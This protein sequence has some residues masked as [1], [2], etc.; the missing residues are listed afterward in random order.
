MLKWT[1]LKKNKYFKIYTAI[2]ILSI[3]LGFLFYFKL[4]ENINISEINLELLIKNHSIYHIL[5]VSITFFL[6]FLLIGS[7]L[8]IMGFCFEL[9][10]IVILGIGLFSA[11]HIRGLFL[12]I[13]LLTFKLF[14]LLL[15]IYLITRGFKI[16]KTIVSKQSHFKGNILIYIKEA[17]YT[18]LII[19][20]IETFNYFIGY[21]II[22]FFTKLLQIML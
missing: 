20:A 15:L 11:Y 8:G 6:S 1:S 10:S 5:F 14:Y 3:L 18:S 22:T 19:I 21:K 9:I 17:I 16:A 12:F 4:K 7:F 13:T 2:S